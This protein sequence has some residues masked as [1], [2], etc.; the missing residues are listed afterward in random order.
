MEDGVGGTLWEVGPLL[1]IQVFG[2][3]QYAEVGHGQGVDFEIQ[4]SGVMRVASILSNPS[5]SIVRMSS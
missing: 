5:L 4:N 1:G 3:V 2:G